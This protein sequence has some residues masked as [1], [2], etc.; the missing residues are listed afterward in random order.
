MGTSGQK[1]RRFYYTG[2]RNSEQ[3]FFASQYENIQ[4]KFISQQG[5]P[6]TFSQPLLTKTGTEIYPLFGQTSV[7][8]LPVRAGA[9]PYFG[10]YGFGRIHSAQSGSPT[11]L[12]VLSSFKKCA[13]GLFTERPVK[14]ARAV[15]GDD[16]G[17]TVDSRP[18]RRSA[19]HTDGRSLHIIKQCAACGKLRLRPKTHTHILGGSHESNRIQ[20]YFAHSGRQLFLHGRLHVGHAADCR[21]FC[22]VRRICHIGRY[23]RRADE[24]LLTFLPSGCR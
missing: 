6:F 17:Q 10:F 1:I 14:N 9:H 8:V 11:P 21:L 2:Y 7:P 4:L 16:P 15:K 20:K 12:F 13:F 3:Q 19:S 24:P 18:D 23:D 5:F 22:A